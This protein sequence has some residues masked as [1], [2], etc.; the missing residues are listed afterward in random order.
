MAR[1]TRSKR[2]VLSSGIES[3]T[4]ISKARRCLE[5][6]KRARYSR[7][8]ARRRSLSVSCSAH[9]RRSHNRR[10]YILNALN[11]ENRARAAWRS[12]PS[13]GRHKSYDY[14]SKGSSSC[15]LIAHLAPRR[16]PDSFSFREIIL[17]A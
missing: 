9:S 16:Q 12:W 15:I 7:A 2:F 6:D 8:K 10:R 1:L 3:E 5:I 11:G 13:N 17:I 14:M 4:S